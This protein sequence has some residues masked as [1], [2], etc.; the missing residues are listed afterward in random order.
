MWCLTSRNSGAAYNNLRLWTTVAIVQYG[1]LPPN[2]SQ[3]LPPPR[4]SGPYHTPP[5]PPPPQ[6]QHRPP[7][8]AIP[9]PPSRVP[10]ALYAVRN[11]LRNHFATATSTPAWSA[12][13]K[14]DQL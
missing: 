6:Q 7:S 11:A 2:P 14:S 8:N 9:A 12:P 10:F 3:H 1:P 4:A 5:P 13:H